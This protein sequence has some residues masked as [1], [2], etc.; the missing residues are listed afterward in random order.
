M[1]LTSL[2]FS[3]QNIPPIADFN[4]DIAFTEDQVRFEQFSGSLAGGPFSLKGQIGLQPL[5]DP[6]IDLRL[7]AKNALLTRNETVTVRANA[8]VSVKGTLK[9]A[10]VTGNVALT[11][12]R[13]FREI[14]ILPLQLPGRPAPKPPAR[15]STVVRLPP[16][17]ADW[18]FDLKI[19]TADPF[20]IRGNLASGNVNLD[21]KF[22]GT[23]KDP[24]LD[25]Y[26]YLDKFVA[27]LPFS[28]LEIVSGYAYFT[29]D[30]PF[31]PVL[32]LY[33]S[34]EIRNYTVSVYI[35]GEASNPE[36][37]FSSE[38]PLPQED[39]I[40]LLATGTT[41]EELTG[42]SSVAAGRAAAIL[43]QKI[44]RTF[45]KQKEPPP[46]GSFLDRFDLDVGTVDPRTGNQ[47]IQAGFQLTDHFLLIGD[48]D[49]QGQ[50]SGQVKYL[51]RFR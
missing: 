4:A 41:T 15:A 48:L 13:F 10:E 43:L 24:A 14:D 25:G 26:A 3:N 32:D 6:A 47:E 20:L 33:G 21:M 29:P 36:T 23:G 40:S 46:P 34:S 27:S 39:I 17:L 9:A 37:L 12:S 7:E 1:R 38:P 42:D 30:N 49:V 11:N 50:L 51:I 45:F 28:Q 22:L 2:R 31:V 44:S 8:D 19:E 16:F 35:Y 18:K 5:T